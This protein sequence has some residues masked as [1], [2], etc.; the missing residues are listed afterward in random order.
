MARRTARKKVAPASTVNEQDET[1]DLNVTD[2][3]DDTTT[4]SPTARPP[5]GVQTAAPAT[6]QP[7][8]RAE[9]GSNAIAVGHPIV[10]NILAQPAATTSTKA[11]DIRYFFSP[12]DVTSIKKRFCKVCE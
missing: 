9:A 12:L 2:S 6:S 5:H 10:N 7:A 1:L 11:S 8:V 3:D 4:E